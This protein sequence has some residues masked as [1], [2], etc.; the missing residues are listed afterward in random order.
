MRTSK[1]FLEKGN[2]KRGWIKNEM[3]THRFIKAVAKYNSFRLASDKNI[4]TADEWA[5]VSFVYRPEIRNM[6]MS[7]QK[8]KSLFK[9][10]E[11]QIY[12]DALLAK[13]LEK[14]GITHEW[15]LS[16]RKE[17]VKGAI[18]HKKYG[19]ANDTLDALEGYR[20]MKITVRT[21]HE[22]ANDVDYDEIDKK[23][24]ESDAVI[25]PDKKIESA[26]NASLAKTNQPQDEPLQ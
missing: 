5:E 25:V 7:I 26:S 13:A 3:R 19:D 18:Q 2:R 12:A 8:T 14:T 20:G 1:D 9:R 10:E 22:E 11:V 23:I 6:K 17:V 24:E 15:L 16:K 4:L 21:Q